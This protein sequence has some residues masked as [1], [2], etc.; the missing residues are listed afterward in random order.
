[1]RLKP[2]LRRIGHDHLERVI[3]AVALDLD[4]EFFARGQP[5]ESV[6]TCSQ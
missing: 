6:G 2:V 5:G 1:M 4:I 3:S